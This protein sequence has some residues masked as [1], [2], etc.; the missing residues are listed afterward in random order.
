MAVKS[1]PLAPDDVGLAALRTD[2]L[3]YIAP[4]GARR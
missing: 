4:R 1:T 3:D 2:Y